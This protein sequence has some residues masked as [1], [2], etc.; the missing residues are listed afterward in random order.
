LG[1]LCRFNAHFEIREASSIYIVTF[2]DKP[3]FKASLYGPSPQ[4]RSKMPSIGLHLE[5]ATTAPTLPIRLAHPRHQ[6]TKPQTLQV[7][8]TKLSTLHLI[9]SI[10]RQTRAISTRAKSASPRN[11]YFIAQTLDFVNHEHEEL[12][13]LLQLTGVGAPFE[14]DVRMMKQ[15]EERRREL[16]AGMLNLDLQCPYL[17]GILSEYKAYTNLMDS[18]EEAENVG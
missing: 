2:E 16:V 11:W 4:T 1:F 10:A 5:S 9:L 3:F 15:M 14:R 6:T 13:V 18:N 7:Y 12:R 17:F 8:S